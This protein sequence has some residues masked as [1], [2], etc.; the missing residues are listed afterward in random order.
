MAA[1]D[2]AR[3]RSIQLELEAD[4]LAALQ[5][6]KRRESRNYLRAAASESELAC[7]LRAL[8]SLGW[9]VLEDRRWPGSKR[10]NVDFLLVGPGGLVVVD[11][12]SWAEVS[13]VD[14]RL[15]RGQADV[16]DEIDIA[17]ALVDRLAEGLE[18]L[19]LTTA[20]ITTIWSFDDLPADKDALGVRFVAAKNL[21][22][23]IAALPRR[24]ST[25]TTTDVAVAVSELCP[26]I[27][28][29][30]SP[31]RLFSRPAPREAIQQDAL[32]GVD[33]LVDALVAHEL[34]EPIESWM[35][36]LHPNQVRLT[37][38]SWNGPARVR[39]P[40]GTGKTVVGLHR[41]T[42]F[43][44]R[45]PHPVLFTSY[46]RTLPA[47]FA[48]LA[49]RLSPA[50][51]KNIHFVGVHQLAS[52]CL[53]KAHRRVRVDPKRAETAF[54]RAWSRSALR[55]SSGF[56]HIS[57]AYWREEI[58]YVIKGRGLESFDQYRDLQRIGRKT[59]LRL[60]DRQLVWELYEA[61]EALLD[62]AE[63]HDFNDL[64]LEA[65]AA[66]RRTPSLFRYSAVV[67]DE[68]QDLPLIAV[69]FLDELSGEGPDRLLIL[70]DSRQSVY[71][72]GF[73]LAEAGIN[74]AGRAHVLKDNY[75]N[76]T[77]ILAVAG[78]H[79]ADESIIDLDGTIDDR[80]E[81]AC[82]RDGN[83]PTLATHATPSESLSAAVVALS[84]SHAAGA[85]WGNMAVLAQT[86]REVAAALAALRAAQIPAMPLSDYTGTSDGRVKV[87]T[88]K[89]A[90]GL[91]FSHVF[92][93]A[94]RAAISQPAHESDSA[95]AERV[96][97]HRRELYV[98]MT[99]ARDHL[100]VSY[101]PTD[102]GSTRGQVGRA[103]LSDLKPVPSH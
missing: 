58:D 87:G 26:P 86:Q 72:G 69:K 17:H 57:S 41:A 7:V 44:L 11:A 53:E 85:P 3:A 45:S 83:S 61:Y 89:R 10:A 98:A 31:A 34:A 54:N 76:T 100:W 33:D 36:F 4:E 24:F 20:A 99:R 50:A 27:E 75:R 18:A 32:P 37:R 22:P 49:E 43:A 14:R 74:V 13:I 88:V 48:Q 63:V 67:I 8:S 1:G 56:A 55:R 82:S 25:S 60:N 15:Y 91:E 101:L 93:P 51:R 28:A 47:V 40:A 52:Q 39:G 30:A 94:V 46:V 68:V 97:R 38:S 66:V 103:D 92:M 19:G 84:D 16:T 81:G 65:H 62:E 102:D 2:S 29:K 79:V 9:R 5:A 77:Q 23:A 78:A 96:G 21:V 80:L 12:K 42:H 90:K 71:P 35:T 73:T 70:G 59:P 6:E 64:I 95:F